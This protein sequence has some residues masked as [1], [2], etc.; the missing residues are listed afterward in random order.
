MCERK[1]DT[2]SLRFPVVGSFALES[3]DGKKKEKNGRSKIAHH[4]TR[5]ENFVFSPRSVF[6]KGDFVSPVIRFLLLVRARRK[7]NIVQVEYSR[8]RWCTNFEGDL[9]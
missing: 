3:H 7:V 6:G 2:L 8:D 5:D 4:K 9:K 1:K